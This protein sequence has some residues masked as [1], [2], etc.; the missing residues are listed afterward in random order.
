M[1]SLL[2]NNFEAGA[3]AAALVADVFDLLEVNERHARLHVAT[4]E[5]RAFRDVPTADRLLRHRRSSGPQESA[6]ANRKRRSLGTP[7]P[8]VT[9]SNPSTRLERPHVPCGTTTRSPRTE[10]AGT[11][12][13]RGG[14]GRFSAGEMLMWQHGPP[15]P[16]C[17]SCARSTALPRPLGWCLCPA[18]RVGLTVLAGDAIWQVATGC[19]LS[20]DLLNMLVAR[21]SAARQDRVRATIRTATAA[22]T[23]T[24]PVEI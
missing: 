24:R 16:R 8:A 20:S 17:R 14:E 12:E 22:Q 1:N 2:L 15:R 7:V 13:E 11:V 9:T 4:R 3:R 21:L 19:H 18:R 6:D 10:L 5:V 23:K